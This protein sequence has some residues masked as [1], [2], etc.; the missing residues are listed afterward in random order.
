MGLAYDANESVEIPNTGREMIK[1]A[2]RLAAGALPEEGENKIKQ[3]KKRVARK[4]EVALGLEADANAPRERMFRL[5]NGQ[6]QF[7]TY[8][9]DKH[10]EDYKAMAR[11]KKNHYQLTWKQIRAK[12]NTFKTIPEQY[13]QYLASKNQTTVSDDESTE[14]T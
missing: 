1:Q 2:K 14:S 9:I 10:G 11:D 7:L 8:L 4:Q 12:I 6:V 13:G 3:V 5:P